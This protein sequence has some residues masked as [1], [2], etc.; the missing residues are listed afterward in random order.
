[1][2]NVRPRLGNRSRNVEDDL[3]RKRIIAIVDALVRP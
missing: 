1:M 2:I 3:L